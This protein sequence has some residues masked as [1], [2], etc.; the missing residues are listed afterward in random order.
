MNNFYWLT[1]LL[2]ALKEKCDETIQ[3]LHN[4]RYPMGYLHKQVASKIY[5]HIMY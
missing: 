3:V 1:S 5:I 2:E 4:A